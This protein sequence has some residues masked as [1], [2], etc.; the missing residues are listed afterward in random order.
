MEPDHRYLKHSISG[1]SLLGRVVSNAV[2]IG[3]VS[4]RLIHVDVLYEVMNT[5][6]ESGASSIVGKD[7]HGDIAHGRW[8]TACMLVT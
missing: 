7:Y 5:N 3:Q 6:T 2:V 1:S 4:V 8:H